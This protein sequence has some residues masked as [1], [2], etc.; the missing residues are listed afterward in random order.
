MSTH[1]IHQLE[2]YQ[3]PNFLIERVSLAFDLDKKETRVRSTLHINRAKDADSKASL[4]LDGEALT[5]VSVRLEGKLLTDKQ[6]KIKE[7]RLIIPN[8]PNKFDLDIEVIISPVDNKTLS[9][10]YLSRHNYCTQCE[11]KGFR[12][13]TYFMDRP[14]VMS[15]FT[16]RITADPKQY[17]ILLSN[18]DLIE[19]KDLDNG[20]REVTWHD[21]S[22]KP[23]YLFALVAGDFDELKDQFKTCSGKIVD[24]FLYVEK[25]YIDQAKYALDSLK[26]AMQ[27]DEEAF[28][29]E[30]DLHRYT[31]VAVSDFNSGAMENKAL[32][33][34]NTKYVL[35]KPETATDEDYIC[36]EDV[37]G[38]EYFHNWTGDRVT[39]LNWFE[40]TL[41][42]GL[43]VFRDQLFTEDR[44][45]KLLGRMR[46]AKVILDRQFA[47]DAG[48]T[49]HPIRPNQYMAVDNL[50]TT[51]I[52]YKGAEVI[53]MLRT[54]VGVEGF[55]KGM[56]LYFERHD[57]QAV[58]TE[59]FVL[60]IADANKR[61]FTQFKRWY[62]QRGTPIVHV[63]DEYDAVNKTYTL[64]IEQKPPKVC[65]KPLTNVEPFHFPVTIGLLDEKGDSLDIN[66]SD[67]GI[68]A[69]KNSTLEITQPKHSFLLTNVQSH[70]IPSL[71]R[72]FSAPV[73]LHYDYTIDDLV[74]L[75]Q[76]DSDEFNRWMASKTLMTRIILTL[77][78]K[79]LSELPHCAEP[80]VLAFK[81]L[82]SQE[83][84]D[85]YLLGQVLMMPTLAHVMQNSDQPIDPH[86]IVEVHQAL[87]RHLATALKDLWLICYKRTKTGPYQYNVKAMSQRV[88]KNVCLTYLLATQTEQADQ[89]AINQY[90]ESDNMTDSLAVLQA[91][92]HHVSKVREKIMQ[93]FY[94]KWKT[95]PLV[96][97][98]WLSI[99]AS[100]FLQNVLC[101][102]QE[103]M[104]L[105]EFNLE[106]P[107]NVYALVAAF[108]L[109]P[110]GFHLKDGKGYEFL[111][112][113]VITIDRL[114]EESPRL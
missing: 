28:G 18:G 63:S 84:T 89:L 64:I 35:A 68:L 20:K 86:C 46:S 85:A 74:L 83:I 113:Q 15:Q 41:K 12:R 95:Q 99:Q 52:Y 79:D 25:G 2:D 108:S 71:L 103:C 40:L 75:M 112:K 26:H 91:L 77:A 14:D 73:K 69:Q 7:K 45:T 11:S 16:V 56:D 107:N 72:H 36:I 37:V 101:R 24:L 102:V 54:I 70:P 47:E 6:Y 43:T 42:E 94:K 21:S 48:P 82:L 111:V 90:E 60:A 33:I 29:R 105:P 9:G 58:T 100:A 8:V 30:Y 1:T 93:D 22:K 62:S 53:R 39:C 98:K 13:I 81:S 34:F 49:A 10:L 88:L 97:N 67:L 110:Y 65:G 106:N 78:D 76:H 31:I 55:R 44:T 104:Q 17:P 38:H 5:L 4:E 80:L 96:F 23:C 66:I 87:Q 57:G 61:D 19:Q 27:W 59:D 109:N 3:K 51:T 50:Y 92:N 114:L 32:N